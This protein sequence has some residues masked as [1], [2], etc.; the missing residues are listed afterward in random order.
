[1]RLRAASPIVAA[2]RGEEK[3]RCNAWVSAAI[4]PTGKTQPSTPSLIK[5]AW[6]P[7]SV[8][9]ITGHPDAIAS[10]TIRP[11]GSCRDGRTKTSASW[12]KRG[13]SD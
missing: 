7:T 6:Q 9:T 8:D 1:M 10:F 13:S 4:S 3:T 2:E 5:S 12:K 11:H